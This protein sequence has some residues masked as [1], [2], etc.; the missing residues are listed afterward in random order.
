MFIPMH[1][2]ADPRG[3]AVQGL[4][5]HSLACWDLSRPGSQTPPKDEEKAL[6]LKPGALSLMI[7]VIDRLDRRLPKGGHL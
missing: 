7:I 4:V 1:Q 6:E 5:L 3:R 2:G